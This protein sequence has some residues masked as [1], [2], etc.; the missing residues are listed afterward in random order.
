M[1]SGPIRCKQ[2]L[3]VGGLN[4]GQRTDNTEQGVNFKSLPVRYSLTTAP[5]SPPP[6]TG[7]FTLAAVCVS[8]ILVCLKRLFLHLAPVCPATAK[9]DKQSKTFLKCR[10]TT[11]LC[12]CSSPH[13]HD[14][15]LSLCFYTRTRART[16]THLQCP[17]QQRYH[18]C[19]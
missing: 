16:H 6:I 18:V 3:K 10:Y 15:L 2:R 4:S 12:P 9:T 8:A 17:H 7:S 1:L 11:L 13:T 19:L 14:S 5:V